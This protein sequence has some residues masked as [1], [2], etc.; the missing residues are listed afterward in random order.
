M[1]K[2]LQCIGIFLWIGFGLLYIAAKIHFFTRYQAV[3]TGE[4]LEQHW[5]FWAG[6]ALVSGL[7]W[8]IGWTKGRFDRARPG[9]R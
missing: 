4:Y 7:L 9:P 1:A 3:S 8:L 2:W 5:R 6:M